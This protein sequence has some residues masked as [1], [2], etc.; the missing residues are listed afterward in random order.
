MP[1]AVLRRPGAKGKAA[2]APRRR[3]PAAAIDP[4]AA[5]EEDLRSK[6][7]GEWLRLELVEIEGKYWDESCVLAG[8]IKGLLKEEGEPFIK[9]RVEGT[10][11]ESLLK[12]L[13][14]VSSR[15]VRCHI[16][17]KPCSRQTWSNDLVHMEKMTEVVGAPEAWMSNLLGVGDAPVREDELAALRKEAERLEAEKGRQKSRERSRKRGRSK[18]RRRSSSGSRKERMKVRPKKKAEHLYEDTGLDPRKKVR[19]QFLRKSKKL[20]RKRLKRKGAS[21]KS[22]SSSRSATPEDE[23]TQGA[24]RQDKLFGE[25]AMVAEVAEDFPGALTSAWLGSAQEFLLMT[26]GERE[27]ENTEAL[28]ALAMKYTRMVLHSKMSPPMQREAM[29]LSMALDPAKEEASLESPRERRERVEKA[30]EKPTTTKEKGRKRA[31]ER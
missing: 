18:R 30:K 5:R 9:V 14:G 21:E 1:P 25:D 6:P 4:P 22:S 10:K 13:S 12:F 19:R 20:T 2:P 17:D 15:E 27:M 16:C 26:R 31:E 11:S 7:A 28:P 29:T 24:Q 8:K 3:R 23:R